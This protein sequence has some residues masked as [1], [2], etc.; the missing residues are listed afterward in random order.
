MFTNGYQKMLKAVR[1]WFEIARLPT[2]P[3]LIPVKVP[4]DEAKHCRPMNIRQY[5]ALQQRFKR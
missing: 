2:E 3:V 4:I 1:R 5:R